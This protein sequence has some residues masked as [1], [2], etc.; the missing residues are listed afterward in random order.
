MNIRHRIT[1]LVVLTFVSISLIGGY[2]I[3]QSR[4]NASLVKVVTEGVIP[5][6]LA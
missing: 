4:W 5:S 2:A 1:L 3:L 6:A